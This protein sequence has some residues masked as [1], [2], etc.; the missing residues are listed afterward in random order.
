MEANFFSRLKQFTKGIRRHVA[1]KK[2]L[3]GDVSMV[4]KKKMGYD[5]YN[6]ICE[7]FMKENGEEYNFCTCFLS[8]KWNLMARSENVV[9]A[10]IFYVHWDANCLVF[11]FVKSK[12]DQTGRNRDQ[13]WHVYSNPHTPSICPVLALACYIFSNPGIFCIGTEETE[14]LDELSVEAEV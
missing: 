8:L 14:E 7:L 4:G 6:N 12:G 13:E 2:V 5:V 3:Q 11:C 1:D 9:H 10:H